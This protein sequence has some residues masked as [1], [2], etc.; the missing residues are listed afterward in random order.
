MR[1]NPNDNRSIVRYEPQ[2]DL[3]RKK[4]GE[5]R[6]FP[7][8]LRPRRARRSG[9]SPISARSYPLAMP[10]NRDC[11]Q[12]VHVDDARTLF[13]AGHGLLRDPSPG[14][15]RLTPARLYRGIEELGFVQVDTISTVRRAHHHILHTRFDDYEPA[16]LK[17]LLERQRRVFE[18]W[19]HDASIIPA[20]WMPHWKRRFRLYAQRHD[21]A[22]TWLRRR[23]GDDWQAVIDHVLERID[24]EGPLRSV[25]FEHERNAGGSWWSWKPQK[26]ALEYLWRIGTLTVTARHNFQKVYDRTERVYP[27]CHADDEADEREHLEWACATALDRL[28]FATAS[29]LAAFFDA[30]KTADAR[31]WITDAARDGRVVDVQVEF[32]DGSAPRKAVAWHDW[33]RRLSRCSPPPDRMRLLSPFDPVVRDRDRALR[34]FHFEYRFEAFVPAAKRTY[35]YYVLPILDSDTIVGRLDAKTHR[36]R[37][38]LEVK[39]LWWEP[40]VR[41]T[42]KLQSR[43]DSALHRLAESV[44]VDDVIRND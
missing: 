36:D 21:R 40:N 17:T 24:S 31:Q 5:T 13:L 19:T 27:Q 8:P 44:G 22:D 15:R 32:A 14:S 16:L 25:D 2:R 34:L 6:K 43:L 9:L 7:R 28:G 42:K 30:V 11:P 26:A 10:R 29:E 20:V 35:G 41:I 18:H 1:L 37:G 39:G 33:R 38:E 4:S 12:T 3:G 23:M